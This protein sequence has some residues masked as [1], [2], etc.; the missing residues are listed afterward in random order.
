[1]DETTFEGEF[2]EVEKESVVD[3][4]PCANEQSSS[5]SYPSREILESQEKVKELA[6]EL[7][8]VS[9]TLKHSES[10]NIM[11]NNKVFFLQRRSWKKV[12]NDTMSLSSATRNYR[13][14]FMILKRDIMCSLIH[15]K[16]YCK[17][18]KQS[19]RS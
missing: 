9:G 4:K 7:L 16:R 19:K 6:L 15:C 17:L 13:I 14:R 1:M 18:K 3:G 10:E 8:A 12:G 2:V 5:N 11:L